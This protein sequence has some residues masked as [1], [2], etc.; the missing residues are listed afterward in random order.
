MNMRCITATCRFDCMAAISK[1]VAQAVAAK[2]PIHMDYQRTSPCL[3]P[4]WAVYID[5]DGSTVPCCNLR[6]DIPSHAGYVIGKLTQQPDLFLQY[7]SRF[8]ANFRTSLIKDGVKKGLCSNCH[9][10]EERPS[11]QQTIQLADLLATR[12][13]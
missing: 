8:A 4:F 9:Y 13:R 12:E 10:A 5:H 11:Q 6:S 3:I 1:Q 2:F 7:A